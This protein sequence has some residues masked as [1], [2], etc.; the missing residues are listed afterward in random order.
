MMESAQLDLLEYTPPRAMQ[1][2]A[3]AAHAEENLPGWKRQAAAWIR[4]Y[5]ATHYEFVSEDCTDAG[6]EAGVP[7]PTDPRAWG[8]MY[9]YC[10]KAGIIRNAG[11]GR[12]KKRASPTTLWHSCHPNFARPA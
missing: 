12:S 4:K 3:V 2:D 11:T 5:S 10:D 7:A 8:H 1:V 9:R 6:Y